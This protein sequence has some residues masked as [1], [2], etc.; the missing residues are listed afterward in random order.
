MNNRYLDENSNIIEA[1]SDDEIETLQPP[2]QIRRT[3]QR[4]ESFNVC[5]HKQAVFQY[6]KDQLYELLLQHGVSIFIC[7]RFLCKI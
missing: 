2:R 4:T 5:D 1:S 6:D 3:I 7:D